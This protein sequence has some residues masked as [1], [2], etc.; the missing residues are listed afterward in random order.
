M[1]VLFLCTADNECIP[2]DHPRR[3]HVS[4]FVLKELKL[5]YETPLP[6]EGHHIING[7]QSHNHWWVNSLYH[8]VCV[9]MQAMRKNFFMRGYISHILRKHNLVGGYNGDIRPSYSQE[10]VTNYT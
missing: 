10:M 7:L 1:L 2:R 4:T 5:S 9:C 6:P 8:V 3:H